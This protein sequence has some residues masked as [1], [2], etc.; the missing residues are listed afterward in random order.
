MRLD[1]C[2]PLLLAVRLAKV[3][4]VEFLLKN[5]AN[6]NAVDFLNRSALILAV[7][8]GEKDIVVLLLQQH[9][10][11]VFSRDAH[12]KTAEDYAIETRNKVVNERLELSKLIRIFPRRG[13]VRHTVK[14][15]D[16]ISTRFLGS[17]DSLTSSEVSSEKQPACKVTS[18]QKDS[19]LNI[20]TEIKDGQKSGTVSSQKETALKAT[21]DKEDSVSNTATEIKDGQQSGT[22]SCQ[23]QPALKA[24][25]DK[26]DSVSNTATEIKDAQIY[27]T[28]GTVLNEYILVEINW[29]SEQNKA[30]L[31]EEECIVIY[32][33]ALLPKREIA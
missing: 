21:S 28:D 6:I 11:D 18:D 26:E 2:Q 4:M 12:G 5:N 10:I 13:F 33:K 22:V 25:S 14:D 17:V 16:H 23:K 7:T 29:K 31:N 8:L 19:I 1:E 24:T 30:S 27:G 15:R 3:N 32:S 20:T 9:N